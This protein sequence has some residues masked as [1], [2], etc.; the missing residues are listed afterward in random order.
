METPD[1]PAAAGSIFSPST[2]GVGPDATNAAVPNVKNATV[3]YTPKFK[4]KELADTFKSIKIPFVKQHVSPYEGKGNQVKYEKGKTYRIKGE[5]EKQDNKDMHGRFDIN[6]DDSVTNDI[7]LLEPWVSL[8]IKTIY[9]KVPDLALKKYLFARFKTIR[10]TIREEFEISYGDEFETDEW[11]PDSNSNE[12]DLQALLDKIT[13]A[14]L[15]VDPNARTA[16]ATKVDGIVQ[17]LNQTSISDG[18]SKTDGGDSGG[19]NPGG[20]GA[21]SQYVDLRF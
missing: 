10:N 4:T 18:A 8:R 17:E 6:T 11:E 13:S 9:L 3:Y 20:G 12:T 21:A 2:T 5:Y 1:K 14:L 19:A 7:I 15:K 16:F